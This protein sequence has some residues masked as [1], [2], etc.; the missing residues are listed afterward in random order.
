MVEVAS[1]KTSFTFSAIYPSTKFHALKLLREDL[2]NF[3][4]D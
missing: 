1:S 3:A 4:C 2:E